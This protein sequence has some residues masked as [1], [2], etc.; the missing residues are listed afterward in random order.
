MMF[1]TTKLSA[2][3]R[4]GLAGVPGRLLLPELNGFGLFRR[5]GHDK[6]H[7]RRDRARFAAANYLLGGCLLSEHPVHPGAADRADALGHPTSFDLVHLSVEIMFLSAFHAVPVVSG[8][9]RRFY[10][11][12]SFTGQGTRRATRCTRPRRCG[13]FRF[14]R[15]AAAGGGTVGLRCWVF[16][17]RGSASARLR[18]EESRMV[19]GQGPDQGLVVQL[20]P[21][22]VDV[23]RSLGYYGGIAV[24][25]G[26][27]VIDPPL[28]L[29]IAAIRP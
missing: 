26:V 22:K 15:A 4:Q 23:P 20:G 21:L 14:C 13:S 11:M 8:R 5:F 9:C 25:V 12:D 29:F 19:Q 28:A 6:C 24:A 2:Q 10:R 17:L 18:W 27:G 3:R 16:E 7:P 1:Q